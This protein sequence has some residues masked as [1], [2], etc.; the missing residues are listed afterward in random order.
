MMSALP[1]KADIVP[2]GGDVRFVLFATKRIAAKFGLLDHP[3]GGDE[4]LLRHCQ[5]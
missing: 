5:P 1:P 2:H 4:K 3:V